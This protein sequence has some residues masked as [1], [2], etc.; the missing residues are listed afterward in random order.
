MRAAR[1]E[2]DLDAVAHNVAAFVPRSDGIVFWLEL[3]LNVVPSPS[4]MS[5]RTEP[6]C[7]VLT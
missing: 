3:R 1:A 4:S 5:I 2:V 6:C 7:H